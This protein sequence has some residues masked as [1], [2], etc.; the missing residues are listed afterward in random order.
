MTPRSDLGRICRT[1]WKNSDRDR[2][3]R[4]SDE[5]AGL[6]VGIVLI[7]A[8]T[9]LGL[10]WLARDVDR[11]VSNRSTAQS[12]AF[13]AARSGSQAT[14]IG[15]VRGATATVAID[16]DEARRRAA[17]TADELFTSYGVDGSVTSIDVGVDE[18]TVTVEI[19]DGSITVTGAGTARSVRAP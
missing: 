13:Q 17:T 11:G 12:I 19:V 7:F 3:R 2:R 14:A 4:R 1:S 8:F 6:V 5:G 10:V 9:F 16:E 15:A 18:V